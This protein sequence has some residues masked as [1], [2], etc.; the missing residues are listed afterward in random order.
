MLAFLGLMAAALAAAEAAPA[1]AP[2]V[3]PATG[4]RL[5]ILGTGTPNA[6]PARSGPALAIMVDGEPYIVDAGP[7]VV[8]RAAAA[9]IPISKLDTGF[10]THLHSDHTLG[11]P[12][13]I[14]SPWTLEREAP[15][16]LYGPPGLKRMVK[17]IE[18][19][20][21]EDVRMRIDGL[22]PAN[23]TGWRAEGTE[24][25]SGGAV[26]EDGALKVEAIPVPHGDWKYAYGYKFSAYGKTIVVS[27]DAG[28]T[29]ALIEAARGADILV[30]EVYSDEGFKKRPPE[31]QTYHKSFHTSASELAAIAKEARPKLLV[32]YHQLYWGA[33]DE[34]LV[35]EIR[36]TGYEGDV[37][38]ASD[39]DVFE[40]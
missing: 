24:I 21:R 39:L 3:E 9:A 5:I 31:W 14:L 10:I 16:R 33:S 19:A 29:E 13:L 35:A 38:S 15:I 20:W 8:R 12:D 37:V 32:L 25:K 11:L 23:V 34:D 40:P 22:E 4:M 18:A 6:D 17:N 28:P 36:A 30:H 27:G 26:F 2:T 1:A 7:G